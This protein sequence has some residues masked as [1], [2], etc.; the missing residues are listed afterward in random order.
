[1]QPSTPFE[2]FDHHVRRSEFDAAQK[3][4]DEHPGLV[5]ARDPRH[6]D[7]TLHAMVDY[8]M[9][10]NVKWLLDRGASLSTPSGDGMLSLHIAAN[11]DDGPMV[12]FLLDQGA[13]I[14]ALDGQGMTP[15]LHA[16]FHGS[17]MAVEHLLNRGANIEAR[18]R[19]GFSMLGCFL[20]GHQRR[21]WD[22]SVRTAEFLEK[23]YCTSERIQV[24]WEDFQR[25]QAM[26][27]DGLNQHPGLGAAIEAFY[28]QVK[29]QLPEPDRAPAAPK[30][31]F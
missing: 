14:E 4:L 27:G 1:M 17:E 21:D 23:H 18:D 5:H 24:A 12:D 19:D 25:A 22:Q 31:R 11:V 6:G 9:T 8:G 7:T 13:D 30:P 29:M 28:L 20:R 10:K 16:A 3:V 26:P 2:H 15:L